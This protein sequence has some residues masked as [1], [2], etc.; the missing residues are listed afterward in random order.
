MHQNFRSRHYSN[1]SGIIVLVKWL[2]AH[3]GVLQLTEAS[4]LGPNSPRTSPENETVKHCRRQM[5]GE[6][7][8]PVAV[9][10]MMPN[11]M[12]PFMT[13]FS[14][15][16]KSSLFCLHSSA[17]SSDVYIS[18][19]FTNSEPRHC[20]WLLPNHARRCLTVE[21]LL[22]WSHSQTTPWAPA[23]LSR[24][25]GPACYPLNPAQLSHGWLLTYWFF[26]ANSGRKNSIRILNQYPL[27]RNLSIWAQFICFIKYLSF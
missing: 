5:T 26:L 27:L 8:S 17:H 4:F 21:Q 18:C 12:K 10:N 3:C 13:Q 6:L 24:T 23:I 20:F 1:Q 9:M 22:Y 2:R 15:N 19:H 7:S 16:F 25:P 11:M 14:S